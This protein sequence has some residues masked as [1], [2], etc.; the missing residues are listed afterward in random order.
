MSRKK[1]TARIS[2]DQSTYLCKL[3]EN[4]NGK[5]DKI[6]SD[7]EVKCWGKKEEYLKQ[8][9]NNKKK[10]IKKSNWWREE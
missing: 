10:K 6:V 4:C 2:K 9:V 5:W 8:H 1:S 3:F 7:K